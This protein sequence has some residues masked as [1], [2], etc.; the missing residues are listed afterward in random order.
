MAMTRPQ[1]TR[2][3]WTLRSSFH[4]VRSPWRVWSLYRAVARVFFYRGEWN[5]GSKGRERGGVLGKGA[6]SPLPPAMGSGECC[7]LL[8]VVRSRDPAAKRRV[9][10]PGSLVLFVVPRFTH[11][12][13]AKAR[14]TRNN[15]GCLGCLSGRYGTALSYRVGI[16]RSP[17]FCARWTYSLG[18]RG[19]VGPKIMPLPHS[20]FGRCRS[21]NGMSLRRNL[22]TF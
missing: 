6:G 18:L 20:Q 14:A 9:A 21:S 5:F 3:Q 13:F 1:G 10:S 11:A 22:R 19:T 15:R 7:K 12:T 2:E 17:I 8:S 4:L 16:C